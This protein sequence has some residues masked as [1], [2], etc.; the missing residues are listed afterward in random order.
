M[1]RSKIKIANQKL[2]I[3]P[4]KAREG[5]KAIHEFTKI[6]MDASPYL[7]LLSERPRVI[8]AATFAKM[9][10]EVNGFDDFIFNIVSLSTG[11]DV[12]V[13]EKDAT[14]KELLDVFMLTIKINDWDA[15]WKI[16]YSLRVTDRESLMAWVYSKASK[17]R[18]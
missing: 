12:D 9:V 6:I 18:I 2:D 15:Y 8:R 10:N 11:I 4:L 5:L 14:L 7:A 1:L 16:A 17:V 13:L 3:K